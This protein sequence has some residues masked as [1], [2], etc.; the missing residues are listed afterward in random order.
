M[1]WSAVLRQ[2]AGVPEEAPS[3]FIPFGSTDPYIPASFAS[4][5]SGEAGPYTPPAVNEAHAAQKEAAPQLM[6]EYMSALE[7]IDPATAAR[8]AATLEAQR[9]NEL[10]QQWV[11]GGGGTG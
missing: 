5:S 6:A 4:G 3:T 10:N 11:L 9:L 2:I 1:A 8:V 7:A